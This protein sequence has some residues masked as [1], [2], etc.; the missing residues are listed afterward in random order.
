M[1]NYY[2]IGETQYKGETQYI[3]ETLCLGSAWQPTA[4]TNNK[5]RTD[6]GLNTNWKYRRYMQKCATDIMKTNTM[7]YFN[8]SGN[9]P[10]IVHHNNP[11]NN[12]PFLFNSIHQDAQPLP[13]SDLKNDYLT[14]VRMKSRMVAPSIPTNSFGIKLGK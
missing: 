8:A 6:A 7:Q 10:Y 2:T 13:N 3:N 9:N 1:N 11:V 4:T 5:L 14:K 12:T